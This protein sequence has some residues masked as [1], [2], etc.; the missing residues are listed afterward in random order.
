MSKETQL[1]PEQELRK[2]EWFRRLT[3]FI[4]TAN[5]KTWASDGPEVTP[6]RPGYKELV[7]PY[8]EDQM[9]EQDKEEYKGYED[10]ELRD[11]Y[12]GYFRA[13]GMTTVY[14]KGKPA[15]TMQYGGHGQTERQEDKVKGT[16]EFLRRALMRVP[17]ELPLRGPKLYEEENK[18]Y[19]FEMLEGNIEE[20]LWR[21]KIIEDGEVT[22]TQ[23]GLTGIIINKDVNRLPINPWDL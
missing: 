6:Q 3:T 18:R 22:F 1:T 4:I 11:S 12:T 8:P 5:K 15:W 21:E 2:A 19:E 14:Y 13:P 9:S 7:W 10:W 20:G 17:P 16:F 23:T